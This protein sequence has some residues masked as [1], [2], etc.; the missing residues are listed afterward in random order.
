MNWWK[1]KK[2]HKLK[3]KPYKEWTIDE[4]TEGVKHDY[5]MIITILTGYAIFMIGYIT[6]VAL[7]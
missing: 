2:E 1:Y 6:W 7:K 4:L 3:G 5:N